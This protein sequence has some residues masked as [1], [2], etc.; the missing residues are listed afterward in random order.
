MVGKAK[1][2]AHTSSAVDY[3][4]KKDKGEIIDKVNCTGDTGKEIKEDFSFFQ[5]MNGKTENNTISIVLSPEP[6]DGKALNKQQMKD[7]SRDFLKKMKL[8]NHQS[9]IIQHTDKAHKHLHIFVNRIDFDGKAYKDNFIGKKAQNMADEVAQERGL[10][11][12][13]EVGMQNKI[14]TKDIKAEIKG[15]SDKVLNGGVTNF[16]DYSKKME[17]LGVKILPTINKQGEMQGFRIDF[18]GFNFKASEVHAN[19]SINKIKMAFN[20]IKNILTKSMGHGMGM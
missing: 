18:K 9:I 17:Q 7:I 11:R 6:K 12:A 2:I 4:L 20:I 15:I 8:E 16:Q 13:R 14:L 5:K 1:S 10:I 19:L 3:A